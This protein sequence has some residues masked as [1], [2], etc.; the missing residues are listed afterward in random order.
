VNIGH[1]SHSACKPQNS[2]IFERE[3]PFQSGRICYQVFASGGLNTNSPHTG[4]S[5]L[6]LGSLISMISIIFGSAVTMKIEY[7]RLDD[8][9]FFAALRLSLADMRLLPAAQQP[10]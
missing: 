3:Q 10:H 5:T 9:S 8:L 2:W 4:M 7:Y 1:E 6:A